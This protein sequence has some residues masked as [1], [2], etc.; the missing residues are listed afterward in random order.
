MAETWL[1]LGTSN[2]IRESGY[3][4]HLA[5]LRPDIEIR[6]AGIGDSPSAMLAYA[7]DGLSL[8]G[9]DR[10]VIDTLVN[11]AAQVE[12]GQADPLACE[13]A[14]F[15]TLHW[16][17]ARGLPVC[18][19]L[20]PQMAPGA[21]ARALHRRRAEWA[22]VH[23]VAVVDGV[24]IAAALRRDAGL[25]DARL[26]VDPLH[27]SWPVTILI[28]QR[29]ARLD[30]TRRAASDAPAPGRVV[31]LAPQVTRSTR[32]LTAGYAVLGPDAGTRI[33]LP[34]PATLFALA[35][36]RLRTPGRI[37]V[38][39]ESGH[40][41]LDPVQVAAQDV[42]A[43]SGMIH[44]VASIHPALQGR[45]FTLA[46]LPGPDGAPAAAEV[47]AA[48]FRDAGAPAPGLWDGVA[49]PLDADVEEVAEALPLEERAVALAAGMAVGSA[50]GETAAEYFR[51]RIAEGRPLWQRRPAQAARVLAR[52]GVALGEVAAAD[53]ILRL[54]A[55]EDAG[56]GTG[57]DAGGDGRADREGRRRRRAR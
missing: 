30:T 5:R 25:D 37:V 40:A 54:G 4:S 9:I 15:E 38:T 13:Q 2:T 20:M 17:T 3:R 18:L 22:R 56:D 36:N 42:G 32:L 21:V 14:L 57:K 34:A 23:G 8:D 26:F 49:T 41:V 1:L 45:S 53:R 10:V 12:A 46:A 48:V 35:V 28:A 50:A 19:L 31:R 33:D 55:A 6:V 43:P 39:A 29:L 16:L 27:A 24:A 44:L 52:L 51:A 47:E 11:D 7:L